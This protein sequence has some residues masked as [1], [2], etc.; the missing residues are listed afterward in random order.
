[1]FDNMSLHAPEEDVKSFPYVQVLPLPVHYGHVSHFLA[2]SG[3]LQLYC[4]PEIQRDLQ[5]VT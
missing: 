1:M 2:H 3:G 5:Q 4:S